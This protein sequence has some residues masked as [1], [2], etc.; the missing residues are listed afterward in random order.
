MF[1]KIRYFL[2]E[3]EKKEK[4]SFENWEGGE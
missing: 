4:E 2:K 1:E 3:K